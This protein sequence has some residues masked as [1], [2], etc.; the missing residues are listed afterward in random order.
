IYVKPFVRWVWLGGILM[1]LGG[2]LALLDKRYRRSKVSIPEPV[3]A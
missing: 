2:L 1:A 3:D